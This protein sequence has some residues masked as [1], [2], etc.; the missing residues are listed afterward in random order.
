[1]K[2]QVK[3]ENLIE[4]HRNLENALAVV[5]DIRYPYP[6]LKD[7]LSVAVDMMDQAI[8][9]KMDV[10]KEDLLDV[11]ET[12]TNS[13][14][15]LK[16]HGPSQK[17]TDDLSLSVQMVDRLIKPDQVLSE[18]GF[19]VADLIRSPEGKIHTVEQLRT[20]L[21]EHVDLDH[22]DRYSGWDPDDYKQENIQDF[23]NEWEKTRTNLKEGTMDDLIKY[24][25]DTRINLTTVPPKELT[26]EDYEKEDSPKFIDVDQLRSAGK[27]E[28]E[29]LNQQPNMKYNIGDIVNSKITFPDNNVEQ[30]R[31][32]VIV[33]KNTALSLYSGANLT[34]QD[35]SWLE[36]SVFVYKDEVNKLK[37]D[38]YVKTD[39]LYTLNAEMIE[40]KKGSLASEDLQLVQA[41]IRQMKEKGKVKTQELPDL[42][43]V[44]DRIID[45][46]KER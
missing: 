20:A 5:K 31:F 29:F 12:L 22:N 45:Q 44:K 33:G 42:S 32:L 37:Y 6:E 24:I 40:Y 30:R 7:D 26:Y 35:K 21:L 14:E 34:K 23:N 11:K 46:E 13:L 25:K 15:F 3:E 28:R 27:A 36:S 38:S 39:V 1:M 8:H 9:M 4:I 10:K 16:D 18:K 41:K 43:K 19:Y 2:I 17:L